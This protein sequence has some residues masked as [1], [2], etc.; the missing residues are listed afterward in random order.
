MKGELSVYCCS[1]LQTVLVLPQ[2]FLL[3]S[4]VYYCMSHKPCIVVDSLHFAVG[5]SPKLFSNSVLINACE[6]LR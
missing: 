4:I 2:Q 6:L 5:R 3:S 1:C